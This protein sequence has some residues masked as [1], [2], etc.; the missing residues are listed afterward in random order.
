MDHL[1]INQPHFEEENI[2]LSPYD[3]KQTKDEEEII[4]PQHQHEEKK[5]QEDIKMRVPLFIT[6]TIPQAASLKEYLQTLLSTDP[7]NKFC[8]DC[9]HN[10]STHA[11]ISYG[12]FICSSCADVHKY[13]FGQSKSYIKAIFLEQWDD[14]QLKSVSFE[15]GGN[16]PF[17][18]I[19]KEYE[20]SGL[21]IHE[22]YKRPAAVYYLKKHQAEIEGKA[23]SELPPAKD[24]NDTFVRTQSKLVK[25]SDKYERKMISIGDK[26][27]K[28]IEENGWKSKIDNFFMKKLRLEKF[29]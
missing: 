3:K 15:F 17:F 14:Y 22:K 10:Q 8:V 27:E 28:K 9:H 25:M 26:I 19:V 16:K 4:D 11:S 12:T 20:I 18:E 6:S 1:H 7:F 2:S 21:P 13:S 23:F 5:V 24:W 29:S